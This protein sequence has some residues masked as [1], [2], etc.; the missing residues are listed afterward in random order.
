MRVGRWKWDG[1]PSGRAHPCPRTVG[2]RRTCCSRSCLR[3]LGRRRAPRTARC[4]AC[5]TS[6]RR[7]TGRG[8]SGAERGDRGRFSP[9]SSSAEHQQESRAVQLTIANI[10]LTISCVMAVP[11]MC[12]NPTEATAALIC[13]ASSASERPA[14]RS[15]SGIG[16]PEMSVIAGG[17]PVGLKIKW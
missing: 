14:L 13:S 4:R 12:R 6:V 3:P 17:L 1:P 9:V 8:R 15:M 11:L 10:L 5:P 2:S 7:A 16:L